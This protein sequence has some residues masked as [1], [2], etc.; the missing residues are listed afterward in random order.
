M[1][2]PCCL[3]FGSRCNVNRTWLNFFITSAIATAVGVLAAGAVDVA[4]TKIEPIDTDSA[5]ISVAFFV[6]SVVQFLTLIASE[7]WFE[8]LSR[9]KKGK[10][11]QAYAANFAEVALTGVLA[12]VVVAFVRHYEVFGGTLPLEFV[13]SAIAGSVG[14]EK[15]FKFLEV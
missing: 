13:A 4:E 5:R 11:G 6:G 10:R 9:A 1:V 2:N 7:R 3:F 8:R 14:A 12:S 15:G